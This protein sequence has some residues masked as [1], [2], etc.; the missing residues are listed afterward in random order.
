MNACGPEFGP[1]C[2]GEEGSSNVMQYDNGDMYRGE[3]EQASPIYGLSTPPVMGGWS[4]P[5]KLCQCR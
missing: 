5:Q 4:G 3:L 1:G 2:K